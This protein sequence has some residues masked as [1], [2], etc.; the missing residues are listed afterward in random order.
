MMAEINGMSA[1]GPKQTSV[2]APHMSA[3]GGKA[4]SAQIMHLI[5]SGSSAK[6]FIN[7]FESRGTAVLT[8]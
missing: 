8:Y 4:D 3:F 5:T 7:D 1:I 2:A 6:K